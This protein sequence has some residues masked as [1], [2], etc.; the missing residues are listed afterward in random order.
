MYKTILAE[1]QVRARASRAR[2]GSCVFLVGK[3]YSWRVLYE[4]HLIWQKKH[5]RTRTSA[6]KYTQK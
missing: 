3:H 5:K 2:Q 4:T 6:S 1:W